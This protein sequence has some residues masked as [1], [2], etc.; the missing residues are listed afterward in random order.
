MIENNTFIY[1]GVSSQSPFYQF[2]DLRR[3]VNVQVQNRTQ[4][5]NFTS[6][7]QKTNTHT[8]VWKKVLAGVAATG[9]AV[10]GAV[11]G[12]KKFQVKNI[13]NVR[14]AFQEVFMRDDI[15]TEQAREMLKRYKEI[16]KIKDREEYAKALFA[17]AKK[18]FGMEK[19]N[20]K[21]IFENK[22]KS[23]GF[24]RT[25]NSEISITPACTKRQMLN[26]IHHE[27]R[28]A[29]QHELI[30]NMYPELAK[31]AGSSKVQRMV[32]QTT[33][34]L[35][36]KDRLMWKDNKWIFD[37][38]EFSDE[39]WSKYIREKII[40]PLRKKN[41]RRN[42]GKLSP[43]NVPEKYRVFTEKLKNAHITYTDMSENFKKYYANFKEQ[44]ARIAG[45]K[46]NKYVKGNAFEPVKDGI[47]GELFYR[48]SAAD[49]KK[50]WSVIAKA[51]KDGF[52]DAIAKRTKNQ[53]TT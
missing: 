25:D 9:A 20:I 51:F 33:E 35:I 11:Y 36:D 50:C 21:L 37:G 17:E 26:T 15:T 24:C 39:E 6:A 31:N 2:Y 29:K 47:F 53:V 3:K 16:E 41:I 28:H 34:E 13:N 45:R 23:L 22:D 8:P 4:S 52:S 14:K 46:I 18:N 30:Y 32:N 5:T 10:L 19:S 44:D 42:F 40:A 48:T 49:L 43:D 12:V 27:F 1:G 7:I 38:K